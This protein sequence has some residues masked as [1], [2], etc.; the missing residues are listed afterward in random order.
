MPEGVVSKRSPKPVID[1]LPIEG[2]IIT[3]KHRSPF[4]IVGKPSCKVGEHFL[5]LFRCRLPARQW[6][7]G[8]F[9]R[10]TRPQDAAVKGFL[11]RVSNSAELSQLSSPW[12]TS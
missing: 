3:N 11:G 10:G 12:A 9:N 6:N 7:R 8:I 5:F 4:N 2:R 1:P